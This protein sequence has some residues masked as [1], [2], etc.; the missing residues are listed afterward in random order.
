VGEGPRLPPKTFCTSPRLAHHRPL[1]PRPCWRC[2]LLLFH[3]RIPNVHRFSR[4]VLPE[5]I[6]AVVDKE[7]SSGHGLYLVSSSPSTNSSRTSSPNPTSPSSLSGRRLA[8]SITKATLWAGPDKRAV[9]RTGH[10]NGFKP[11]TC[12]H[13]GRGVHPGRPADPRCRVLP[14]GLGEG[15][16]VRAG[17]EVGRSLRF[18]ETRL[19]DLA[20]SS[21]PWSDKLFESR[22]HKADGSWAQIG[23]GPPLGGGPPPT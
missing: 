7:G 8:L 1:S 10:A 22:E 21:I 23:G 2:G 15:P 14:L 11:K 4:G 12:P 9:G 13:Q 18:T 19:H 5:T 20:R 3:L 17:A 16:P 6:S